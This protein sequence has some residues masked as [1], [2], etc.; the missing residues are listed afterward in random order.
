M[1]DPLLYESVEAVMVDAAAAIHH[2]REEWAREISPTVSRIYA[3][4]AGG[5]EALEIVYRSSLNEMTMEEVLKKNRDRDFALGYTSGGVH[6]DDI[7][8]ALDG[9][10]LKDFGS[11][12]Q[13][14]TF[15]IALRMA[16]FE[17]LKRNGGETPL[18]LL[19]DIFDKLDSTRVGRIMELVSAGDTFGQIFIT[20]TNRE[21]LDETLAALSGEK[22]LINVEQGVFTSIL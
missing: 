8:A 14:K 19:Y 2:M 18:L 15:T 7:Y 17:Y 13:V 22:Q 10:A 6:R 9:F 4:I 16:I 20:D 12:G 21:H 11:Q 5:S 1:R 3:H